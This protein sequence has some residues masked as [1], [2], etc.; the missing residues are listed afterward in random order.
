M[1][2]WSV[3]RLSLEN[4]FLKYW[5]L[6][7]LSATFRL[8]SSGQ[9]IMFRHTDSLKWALQKSKENFVQALLRHIL[10]IRHCS[11][12]MSVDRKI[13]VES[14]L[15]THKSCSARPIKDAGFC[16]PIFWIWGHLYLFRVKHLQL[17]LPNT[18]LPYLLV[19]FSYSL[20]FISKPS[21]QWCERNLKI[22]K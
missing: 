21:S 1:C 16:L 6:L 15:S 13:T 3:L 12:Y 9:V 19:L 11:V 7:A 17:S 14:A 4:K 10:F 5:P 8:C 20:L 2:T 18:N 22:R